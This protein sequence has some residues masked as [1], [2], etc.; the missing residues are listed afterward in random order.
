MDVLTFVFYFLLA[1]GIVFIVKK[2]MKI[3]IYVR[4]GRRKNINWAYAITFIVLLFFAVYRYVYDKYGG[5]D[6]YSYVMEF[7]EFDVPLSFY[8]DIK[9]FI[10]FW[11]YSE[12]FFKVLTLI[13]RKI[14]YDYHFYFFIT[15][16]IIISGLLSYVF[17]FYHK[18]SNFFTLIL[19]IA[20]YLHSYNVMRGWMSIS[21]CMFALVAMKQNKWKKALCIIWIASMFH[22][23]ALIF[24]VL[25]AVCWYHGKKP[26]FFTRNKL[27]FL[28]ILINVLTW[29]GKRILYTIAMS[30]KYAF[31]KDYFEMDYSIWGY[32][33]TFSIC[34]A[35]IFFFPKLK[36]RGEDTAMCAI[37]LAVNMSLFY[38]ITCM[39]GWRVH[40]YFALVRMFI[41]SE[42][43]SIM[44]E[45]IK[46]DSSRKIVY[47][48]Y[49]ICILFLFVHALYGLYESSDVFPYILKII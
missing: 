17:N 19:L 46:N 47:L 36:K 5:T 22:Y 49:N 42:L 26:Y 32:L 12:T 3:N 9:R 25:W 1:I 21:I 30:T 29:A 14:T 8:M 13:I 37:I 27:L 20:S 23:M 40:D 34:L 28:V 10:F 45:Y 4:I 38:F 43:Y 39:P 41:L 35:A 16:G 11:D 18:N 44:S 6:A 2:S 33:P 24:V 31:Y 48:L 15:Y 7:Q